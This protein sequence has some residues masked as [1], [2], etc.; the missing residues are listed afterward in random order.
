MKADILLRKDQ[1]DTQDDNKDV[2]MLKEELWTRRQTL[3]EVTLLWR[4]KVVEET[5]LLEEI[6]QNGTRENEV[7]KK[8]KKEGGQIWEDNEI[9]YINRRI[10]IPNNRKIRE[11]ILWENHNSTDVGHLGQ[12]KMMELIKR[13]Y[14]WP[15]IKED[16]KEYV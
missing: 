3:A 1:V 16:V 5:T 9:I 14:W 8:L 13:N 11:Q 6:W 12:Q 15:D 10:Y 2:Q 4:N 7:I